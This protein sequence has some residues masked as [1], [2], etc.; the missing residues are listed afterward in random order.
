VIFGH[1]L[2]ILF[3]FLAILCLVSIYGCIVA[4]WR[5]CDR[6]AD[7]FVYI[8]VASVNIMILGLIILC[9]LHQ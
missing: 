8:G 6:L 1:H 3:S 4:I 2:V 7:I 9:I 5:D